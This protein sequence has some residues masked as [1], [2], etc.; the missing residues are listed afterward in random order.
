MKR[1]L[2][3]TAVGLF[4]AGHGV[5]TAMTFAPLPAMTDCISPS[6]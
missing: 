6:R 4:L 3:L 2:I 5:A 1:I